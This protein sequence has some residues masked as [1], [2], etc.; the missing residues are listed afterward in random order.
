MRGNYQHQLHSPV[1]PSPPSTTASFEIAQSAVGY[2][3]GD[4]RFRTLPSQEH[5]RTPEVR[6]AADQRGGLAK[7]T[8]SRL[9]FNSS[10]ERM[11][12]TWV[13]AVRRLIPSVRAISVQV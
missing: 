4:F 1:L 13:S 12:S 3:V 8:S 10:F 2:L 5:G 7:C 6:G 9:C 11:A